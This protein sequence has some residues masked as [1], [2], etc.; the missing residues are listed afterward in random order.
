MSLNLQERK[1]SIVGLRQSFLLSSFPEEEKG[2]REL[3][4]CGAR[5]HAT[6]GHIVNNKKDKKQGNKCVHT[7]RI[8]KILTKEKMKRWTPKLTQQYD[9]FASA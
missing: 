7:S 3:Q 4:V 6:K 9:H 8:G 2:E 5:E 1:S